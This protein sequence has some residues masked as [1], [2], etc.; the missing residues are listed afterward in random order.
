MRHYRF[1]QAVSLLHHNNGKDTPSTLQE[2]GG[3]ELPSSSL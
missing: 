1:H 2:L 3:E